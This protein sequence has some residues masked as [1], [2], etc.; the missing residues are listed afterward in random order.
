MNNQ[1]CTN[2][3]ENNQRPTFLTVICILSFIGTGF[4][5]LSALIG[6]AMAPFYNAVSEE[7]NVAMDE[8]MGELSSQSPG[9]A[10]F[11]GKIMGTS[12]AIMEHAL[13]INLVNLACSII[14]LFGVIMM[15]KLKKLGFYLYSVSEIIILV[16]PVALIGFSFMLGFSL[17]F[18]FIFTAG[19]IIMYAL[20]LKAMR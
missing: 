8:A 16:L 12:Q 4:S 2:M 3:S 9:F 18:G 11:F 10:S 5:I 6:I 17:V 1:K 19:F 14:A 15:W 7:S 13:I 20:N